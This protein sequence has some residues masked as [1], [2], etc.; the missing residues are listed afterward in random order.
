[1]VKRTAESLQNVWQNKFQEY[2]LNPFTSDVKLGLRYQRLDNPA[3]W[4]FNPTNPDSLRLTKP[5]FR[6]LQQNKEIQSWKFV[7][8]EP[9]VPRTMLLLEKYFK[10]PYFIENFK[11]IHVFDDREAMMIALHD[12]NIRQY[13]D[14][15]DL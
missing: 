7:C 6:M 4:W 10:S 2:Q 13:L 5:S 14:N 8:K 9:I 15:Q 3:A 12:N 1:M 11:I